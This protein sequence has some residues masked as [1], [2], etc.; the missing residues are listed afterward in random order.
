MSTLKLVVADNDFKAYD[1]PTALNTAISRTKQDDIEWLYSVY[2]Q[3]AALEQLKRRDI[4]ALLID[5]DF[6]E[7][8]EGLYKILLNEILPANRIG[9]IS[10]YDYAGLVNQQR[11]NQPKLEGDY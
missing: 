10:A 7:G 9:Y 4:Y 1:V 3:S 8:A 6:G 5:N 2:N 11:L